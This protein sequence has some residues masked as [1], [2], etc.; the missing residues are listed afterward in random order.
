MSLYGITADSNLRLMGTW[1]M[2]IN[3][4]K[5]LDFKVTSPCED[6]GKCRSKNMENM[7]IGF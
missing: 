2:I 5:A 4:K 6:H 1:K 7:R 3:L